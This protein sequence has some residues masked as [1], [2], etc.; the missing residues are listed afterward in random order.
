M[1]FG[2]GWAN[3][4][5]IHNGGSQILKSDMEF[6]WAINMMIVIPMI[7]QNVTFGYILKHFFNNDSIV[8]I[9][10]VLLISAICTL[11]IKQKTKTK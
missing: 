8:A 5:G 3:M 10:L 9:L 1:G 4:M 7:I 11:F 2:I 6:I